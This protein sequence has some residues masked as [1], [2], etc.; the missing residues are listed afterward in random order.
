[1]KRS[2]LSSSRTKR[3]SS[4]WMATFL[5]AIPRKPPTLTTTAFTL[6]SAVISTSSISPASSHWRTS[7]SPTDMPGS[8]S[9]S[10]V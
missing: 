6:R 5:S 2:P 4:A 7:F 9:R 1:M 8:Y 10:A 3:M